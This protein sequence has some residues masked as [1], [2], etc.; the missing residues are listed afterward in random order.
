[1]KKILALIL[2][3]VLMLGMVGT[4]AGCS[5]VEDDDNNVVIATVNGVPILKS[6][7]NK[8]C[9]EFYY[10]YAQYYGEE[11]ALQ[12][13]Q[14]YSSQFIDELVLQELLKQR[15][16]A[17][18]FL[19]YTDE[20]RAEA[21]KKFDEDREAY[22]EEFIANVKPVFEGQTITGKN[23]GETDEAYFRRV[24]AQK[25]AQELADQ[26]T[27]E[28]QIIEETL[29]NNALTKYQEHMLKD[30]VV[31]DGTV[32]EKYTSLYNEQL[33]ELNTDAKYVTAKNGQTVTLSTGSQTTYDIIVYNRPG[34]SMVQQ[35][36]IKFE[37]EDLTKL[38]SIVGQIADYEEEIAGR[39]EDLKD[40]TDEAIKKSTQEAIDAAKK[41]LAEYEEQYKTVLAEACA[42][43]QAK[44]D[45]IYASVKDGDE[46]NFI[47]VL[48]EKT[49]DT[50][51]KTE[52]AAKAGYLVGP[53]DGMVEEFST[54]AQ[55]LEVGAISEP[56][57]TY[58]GYHIIRCIEKIPE[59]K[60]AYEDIK[61]ELTEKL[62][63]EKKSEEWNKMVEL[64]KSEAKIKKY[65]DRID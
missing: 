60:V 59:G 35:I 4:F 61:E 11:T 49:E 55:A 14:Q 10:M 50:G 16:E 33:Q 46:E 41:T 52:E 17:E 64:W 27:S 24:A 5:L 38:E 19:N 44:T 37:D 7:F 48:L 42:K 47:K 57:A 63:D 22:I 39:E 43:I 6:E 29:L 3:V 21:Q 56:V 28:A 1:M 20:D 45:E 18:G 34:Y 31:V 25:Y 30:V 51:M 9:N 62:T 26:G 15:A 36:L 40:E 65:E 53:E 32:Q 8:I 12:Y 58:Y 54:A 23:E 13:V 2:A